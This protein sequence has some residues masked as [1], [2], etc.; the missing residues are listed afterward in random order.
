V[1]RYVADDCHYANV[2]TIHSAKG[3]EYENV[4]LVDS[5]ITGV[6]DRNVAYVGMTRAKDRLLIVNGSIFQILMKKYS[7]NKIII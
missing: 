6:E 2:D 5:E 1:V 3:L 7:Y 4:I